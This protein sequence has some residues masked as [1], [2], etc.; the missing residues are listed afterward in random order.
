MN[1]LFGLLFLA[2]V[3]AGAGVDTPPAGVA[4]LLR[5]RHRRQWLP[6]AAEGAGCCGGTC[7]SQAP[8][9]AAAPP[10]VAP[11]TAPA[12]APAA[13]PAVSRKPSQVAEWFK[14]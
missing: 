9:P 14:P 8:A 13:A 10:A 5:R 4:A 1:M 7:R 3:G 12:A 11:A 6:A 2:Q